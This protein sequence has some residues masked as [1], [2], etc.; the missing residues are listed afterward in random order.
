[1]TVTRYCNALKLGLW[2][3]FSLYIRLNK[4]TSSIVKFPKF[5]GSLELWFSSNLTKEYRKFSNIIFSYD[6]FPETT[7]CTRG[8]YAGNLKSKYPLDSFWPHF[9]R[10]EENH[11]SK[12]PQFLGNF[13]ALD[14]FKSRRML[15][16]KNPKK[17]LKWPTS[18]VTVTFGPWTWLFF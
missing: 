13:H 5:G 10:F 3:V 11:S 8:R 15:R 7:P 12:V 16:L 9:V 14:V 1:M 17:T 6:V 18:G 4:K 2:A